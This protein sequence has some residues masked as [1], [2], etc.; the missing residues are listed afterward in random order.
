M[1]RETRKVT[2][3]IYDALEDGSLTYQQV[4]EAAL[5]F[6]SE[7]DVAEMAHANEL[8]LGM[9]EEDDEDDDESGDDS[10]PM[11]DYNYVGSPH[12]Y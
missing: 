4:A 5:I 6:M 11:D 3:R 10:D 9:D 1:A 7:D 2:N 12:H 8:F